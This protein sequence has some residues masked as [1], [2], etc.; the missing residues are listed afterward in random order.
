[1]FGCSL[2]P[3]IWQ[4]RDKEKKLHKGNERKQVQKK[5]HKANK[6]E[7]ITARTKRSSRRGNRSLQGRKTARAIHGGLANKMSPMR[8]S[9]V[10]TKY[11]MLIV[12]DVSV[13]LGALGILRQTSLL[14]K[15][16][17]GIFT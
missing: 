2:K 3:C 15:F 12:K 7:Q 16:S 10:F 17:N 4:Y 8:T 5:L 9:T 1:M 13:D 6:R 14:V 11:G